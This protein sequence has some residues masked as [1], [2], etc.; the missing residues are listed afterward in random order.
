MLYSVHA[1]LVLSAL[2]TSSW[3]F[4]VL[5]RSGDTC[6]VLVRLGK[7]PVTRK[8]WCREGGGGEGA[9]REGA[10]REVEGRV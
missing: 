8:G 1:V 3:S 5:V 4:M 7:V 10:E 6:P 9:G 2:H